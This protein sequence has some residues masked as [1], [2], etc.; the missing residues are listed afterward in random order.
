MAGIIARKNQE[1]LAESLY[2]NTNFSKQEVL[3]L[4]TMFSEEVK[5]KDKMDRTAF[6]EILRT[7]FSMTDDMLMDR[8][9][10]AFDKD[11]DSFIRM[12][13]WVMGLSDFLRGNL[14]KRTEFCFNVYDL[15]GDS[16]ISKEEIIQ[17]LKNTIVKQSTEEEPDEGVR[18][19]CDIALRITDDDSDNKL[20]LK[21]FK[22][23]VNR[24]TL[25]LEI[26]GQC[27]PNQDD[28]DKFLEEIKDEKENQAKGP[29]SY[30]PRKT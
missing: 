2:K 17:L 24:N 15:N 16:F 10:R 6:R 12:E 26:F 11:T 5:P 13:D 4:L 29:S 8:V 9:F 18:D 30:K 19:L 27:L 23:A 21:D 20:S 7:K 3:N 14:D 28:I 25:L 22:A 1:K